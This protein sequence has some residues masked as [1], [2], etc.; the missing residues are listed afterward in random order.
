MKYSYLK[1]AS[2]P[3]GLDL[4]QLAQTITKVTKLPTKVVGNNIITT[5]FYM[6][7]IS[8]EFLPENSSI[9]LN[10]KASFEFIERP[11]QAIE[12]NFTSE[13]IYTGFGEKTPIILD[14]KFENLIKVTNNDLFE[15]DVERACLSAIKLP[16]R[17]FMAKKEH[18][19]NYINY[20]ENVVKNYNI[21]TTDPGFGM[22]FKDRVLGSIDAFEDGSYWDAILWIL[23]KNR[24]KRDTFS[25]TLS[26]NDMTNL[27]FERVLQLVE[28][29]LKIY[30]RK[31]MLQP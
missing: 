25:F 28:L 27:G 26:K 9:E 18:G 2:N 7:N 11:I 24:F 16:I 14:Q 29:Y 15:D 31:P 12:I 21:L 8:V 19:N 30:L 13:V 5:A 6:P 23:T 1:R 17:I 4:E 22:W 20:L 10:F 3:F